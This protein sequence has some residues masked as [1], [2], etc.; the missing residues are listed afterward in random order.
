MRN[1]QQVDAIATRRV[2]HNNRQTLLSVP[3]MLEKTFAAGRWEAGLAAGVSFNYLTQQS[4]R[5]LNALQ[6]VV[7]YSSGGGES[8]PS[9]DFY[10]SYQI[11]PTINYRLNNQVSIQARA[12]FRWQQYGKSALYE[13]SANSMLYGGSIGVVFGL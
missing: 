9:P 3:L 13:L 4:G 10:L 12:D 5:S 1:G 2:Q 11:R 7:T 8:L 6:Q